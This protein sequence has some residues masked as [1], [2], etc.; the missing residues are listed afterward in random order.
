MKKYIFLLIFD[1]IC[2]VCE[3]Y[4][5]FGFKHL[6]FKKWEVVVVFLTFFYF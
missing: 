5:F 3:L 6:Y 1:H 2:E 4:E